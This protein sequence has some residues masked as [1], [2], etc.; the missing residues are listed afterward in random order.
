MFYII[1]GGEGGGG[2][3]GGAQFTIVRGVR[4]SL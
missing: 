2:V 4:G 1:Q 3:G